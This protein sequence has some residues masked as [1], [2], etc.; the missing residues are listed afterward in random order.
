MRLRQFNG[1]D[2]KYMENDTGER[3]RTKTKNQAT[4]SD[5]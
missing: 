3:M 1:R 5:I 4:K 2:L